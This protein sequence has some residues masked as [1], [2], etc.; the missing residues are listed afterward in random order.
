MNSIAIIGL[1]DIVSSLIAVSI[2]GIIIYHFFNKINAKISQISQIKSKQRLD[3]NYGGG[4]PKYDKKSNDEGISLNELVP[5]DEG[6]SNCRFHNNRVF[7]TNN[8]KNKNSDTNPYVVQDVTN[9]Y[10]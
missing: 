4:I 9:K 3:I 1:L 6:M 2:V 5:D 8:T 10:Y 7:G